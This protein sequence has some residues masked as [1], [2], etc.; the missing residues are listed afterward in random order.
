MVRHIDINTGVS[1]FEAER[2]GNNFDAVSIQSGVKYDWS[3]VGEMANEELDKLKDLNDK[4]MD[5]IEAK[6]HEKNAGILT[7]KQ[8]MK[9]AKESFST[10]EY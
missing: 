10:K 1:T 6:Y 4:K 7:A 3:A 5:A 8:I 9:E 2:I